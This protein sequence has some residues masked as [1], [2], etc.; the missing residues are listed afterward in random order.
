MIPVEFPAGV[1]T[2]LAKSAKIANWRDSNLMRW[3]NGT[4]LKPV[5]G[6]EQIPYAMAFASKVRATHRWVAQSGILYTAYLCEQHVYVESGGILTNI[7]PA[8]G[9]PALGGTEAGYGEL[10]YGED[11]YGTPRAGTSTLQKFSPAWSINNWGEDLLVMLSYDGRLL[12]WSPTTPATPLVAVT[13]APVSNRQFVVTPEHHVVLFQVAGQIADYG[14]CSQEDI[15]D[16][17]FANPLN[18]AGMFTVDPFSPIVAA[19]SS[20]LGFTVHT[21]AMSYFVDYIGLP[22]VYRYKAIG[23]VPIPISAASMSSIPEGIVWISAEGFWLYNGAAADILP[24][25]VWDVIAENMDFGRT[26]RES[27]SVNMLVKGEIWWFW[28]DKALGLNTE[29]YV[30]IDYRSKVWM[31]G[32]LSRT[33]GNTY[34]ND[35]YPI[36]S[37]GVKV[38]KHET[39]FSYPEARFQPYLES[40]TISVAGGERKATVN[41]ILPEIAGDRTALAFSLALIDDRTKK[42][43]ERYSPQRTVN[44]H[45]WVDLRETAR[46]VRL[47]IDMIKPTDWSTVGPIIFDIKPRGKK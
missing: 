35:Q 32:Y 36:M 28:V 25:P 42:S 16:W 9:I 15:N 38:W 29:R 1:T 41:K 4:T 12:I 24:C 26:V 22:Y 34:G 19:H 40:Q 3:D 10:D 13:G 23:K 30:A 7:T 5:N 39:G 47:R 21:P 31:D 44:E 11:N 33:C 37:D 8:G 27:H 14:W 45:G 18:T 2:L 43:N 20:S 17:N 46:D 6:W